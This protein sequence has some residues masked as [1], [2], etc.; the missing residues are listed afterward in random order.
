MTSETF[1][2]WLTSLELELQQKSQMCCTPSFTQFEKHSSRIS[3]FQYHI[4]GEDSR[5]GDHTKFKDIVSQ[6][7]GK[8][9]P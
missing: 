3:A 7:F 9:H 6:K 4:L 1:K 2:K 8:L 5:H